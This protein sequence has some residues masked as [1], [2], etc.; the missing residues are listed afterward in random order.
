MAT[1][2]GGPTAGGKM[3]RVALDAVA[4]NATEVVLPNW[5]RK[6]TLQF[7]TSGGAP[8]AGSVLRGQTQSD[9]AAMSSHAFPISAGAA[10]ELTLSPGQSR[11]L[12]G[13][14]IYVSGTAG[15]VVYLDLEL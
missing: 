13:C 11:Q 8:A 14:T 12:A 7:E 6:C 10:Y 15:G 2:T 9:G 3:E 1:I 5:V 4:G